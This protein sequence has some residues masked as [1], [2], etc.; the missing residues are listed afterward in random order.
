MSYIFDVRET[1]VWSPA[2][3]VGKLYVGMLNA[4]ADVLRLPSGLGDDLGD[5]YEIDPARFGSLV[6]EM[7]STRAASDHQYLWMLLD[8][9]LPISI[10]MLE[11]G[12][13]PVVARGEMEEKYLAMVHAMKLPMAA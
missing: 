3:Q 10:A 2:N 7:L 8:G 5:M 11:R 1:T 9:I 12:G 4:A 6:H 13:V